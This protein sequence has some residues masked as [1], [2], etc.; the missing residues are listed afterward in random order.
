MIAAIDREALEPADTMLT[1]G[2]LEVTPNAPSVVPSEVFFSIDLRHPSNEV[3]DRVDQAIRRIVEDE[4]GP[5]RVELRQIAHAPSLTFSADVRT[6]V[7]QAAERASVPSMEIY[8]AA[9]HDAR[10]L[11]YVCPTGMIFVPCREGISHNPAEWAEPEH[12]T[13]GARVLAD[14]VWALANAR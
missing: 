4:K 14:A 10:Q 7:T 13:A 3:V 1:V 2:L 8:S 5:C 9:G 12:L 6:I 11:H